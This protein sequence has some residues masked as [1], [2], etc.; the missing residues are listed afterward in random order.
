MLVVKVEL[1]SA[2]TGNKTEIARMMIDNIGGDLKS[3]DYRCRTYRGRSALRLERA[4]RWGDVVREGKVLGH[5]R[6]A[7]HVWHLVAKALTA[8]EYGK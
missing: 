2:V 4:M 5:R 3:G 6:L 1:H 8:M 7:L